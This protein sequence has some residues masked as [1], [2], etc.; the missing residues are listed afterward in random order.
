MSV[1][2][3]AS[4]LEHILAEFQ[5]IDLLIRARIQRARE[6]QST[7]AE[8]QGLYISEREVDDLLARPLGLPTWAIGQA[9][10][11][12]AALDQLSETIRRSKAESARRGIPLRLDRRQLFFN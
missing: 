9:L 6:T 5:R 3:Y 10:D 4:S 1:E 12:Q 2:C 11:V 8:L 7:D